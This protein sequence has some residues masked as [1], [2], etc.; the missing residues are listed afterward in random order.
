M[1]SGCG[2]VR[3]TA[4]CTGRL[5]VSPEICTLAAEPGAEAPSSRSGLVPPL[6]S[7][8]NMPA[9]E[10]AGTYEPDGALSTKTLLILIPLTMALVP[11]D[12]GWNSSVGALS[13]ASQPTVA[14]IS[15]ARAPISRRLATV[16]PE[17]LRITANASS[18]RQRERCMHSRGGPRGLLVDYKS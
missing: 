4:D 10:P 5:T 16:L 13:P 18:V 6:K 15:R 11:A 8:R 17:R 2:P 9:D 14:G 1:T 3:L 12:A 7:A